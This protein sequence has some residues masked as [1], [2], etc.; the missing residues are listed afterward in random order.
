MDIAAARRASWH[1]YALRFLFGGLITAVAGIIAKQYGPGIGGLFLAFPAIFPA[2]ATLIEKHEREKKQRRG[3]NPGTRGQQA[4]SADAAGA[5]IG[6]IG[7]MAFAFVVWRFF[8]G[9]G[10][11]LV[12]V[13]ATVLWLSVSVSLWNIWKRV[14]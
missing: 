6:C 13:A 3:V 2:S 11:W 7:L 5:T 14:M 10:S 4:A 1:E 12:L 9:H 8:A